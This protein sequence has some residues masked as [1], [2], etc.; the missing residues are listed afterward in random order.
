MTD[1]SS[2]LNSYHYLSRESEVIGKDP[3]GRLSAVVAI[4]KDE[5]AYLREVLG[6]SGKQHTVRAVNSLP[7]GKIDDSLCSMYV[8]NPAIAAFALSQAI[9]S[10]GIEVGLDRESVVVDLEGLIESQRSFE[11]TYNKDNRR[12]QDCCSGFTDY[13]CSNEIPYN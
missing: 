8:K 9:L 5:K 7:S 4:L 12:D 13:K 10:A 6:F 2:M 1:Y 3:I 11:R